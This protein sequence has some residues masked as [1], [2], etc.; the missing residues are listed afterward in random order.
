MVLLCVVP[1]AEACGDGDGGRRGSSL[2][3]P[4]CPDGA[5]LLPLSFVVRRSER[6]DTLAWDAEDIIITSG[7]FGC[8][9]KQRR[10]LQQT[11]SKSEQIRVNNRWWGL[12]VFRGVFW[13]GSRD[14]LKTYFSLARFWSF[15]LW[16]P[17]CVW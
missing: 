4:C 12:R 2:L 16:L 3:P 8:K 14:A 6:D 17:P 11:L 13:G 9:D 1:A 15:V 10:F 7:L 5:R